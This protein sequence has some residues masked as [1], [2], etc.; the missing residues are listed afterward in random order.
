M[1]TLLGEDPGARAGPEDHGSGG[2]TIRRGARRARSARGLTFIELVVVVVILMVMAAAALPLGR[3]AVKRKNELFLRRALTSMRSA[4]DEYHKYAQAGAIPAWDP[5]WEFY[6]EDLES[7]VEGI[8]VTSPQNPVPKKVIFLRKIPEDPMTGE[9]VWGMRSY[10]DD[11]DSSTWGGE[12]IYDVYSLSAGT[13]LDG[14]LYS[15]W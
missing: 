4:I 12:N 10:Q 11:N 15:S 6:P 7:L 1:I 5:D 14:T 13:A 8:E 2:G 9:A 3:N